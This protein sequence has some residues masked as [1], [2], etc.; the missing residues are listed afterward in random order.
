MLQKDERSTIAGKSQ[1]K[2]TAVLNCLQL[3]SFR[4]FKLCSN[5]KSKILSALILMHCFFFI[6]LQAIVDSRKDRI[7]EGLKSNEVPLQRFYGN[8]TR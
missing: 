3:N 7:V 4:K 1:I 5:K 6:I 2:K 8:K